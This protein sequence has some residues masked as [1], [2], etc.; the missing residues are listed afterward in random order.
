MRVLIFTSSAGTAHDAAAEA[1][2]QWLARLAPEVEVT[3]ASI[4]EDASPAGRAAVDLYNWIQRRAPWLHQLYWRLCE[5]EDLTK[6]GTVLAG[7]GH[8]RALLERVRPDLLISTYPHTNRGHFAFARRVLRRLGQPVR[9]VICCT[10]VDGGFGF[11]RNWVS[12]QA[13]RFWAITPEAAREARRRRTP[14]TR[15]ATLGPLLYPAYHEAPP[16]P[17][18]LAGRPRLVLGTGGNGANNHLA[19]LEQLLPLGDQLEVVALCGKRA[20]VRQQLQ[21]WAAAHPQLP[22]QAQGFLGP[23]AMVELY[24]SAWAMVARPGARTA[25]EALVLGCP[26]IFNVIGTTMPQELLARRYFQDRGLETVIRRPA[27]LAAVVA[28]WLAQP[29][30]YQRRRQ[31]LQLHRLRTDPQLVVEDLLH[32]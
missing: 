31:C 23:E 28:G 20:A 15:I 21:A 29:A 18:V 16:A 30:R 32:G 13:D 10:E 3:V 19:L 11:S 17:L 24:R 6:P 4:L 22:L 5:L 1:L 14:S 27:D 25:T 26:L 2:V 12:R 7:R 8:I 9:C